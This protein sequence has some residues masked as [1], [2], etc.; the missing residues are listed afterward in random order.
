M[1]TESP[2]GVAA[3]L[4]AFAFKFIFADSGT[5]FNAANLETACGAERV[6]HT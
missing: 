2:G 3:I 4:M 1:D 6:I 5:G